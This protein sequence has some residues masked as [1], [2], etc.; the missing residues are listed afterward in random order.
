MDKI[1]STS[2]YDKD[3]VI[4]DDFKERKGFKNRAEAVRVIVEYARA[5]G[6]LA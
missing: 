2:I 5:H 4:V 1:T 6:V 3:L